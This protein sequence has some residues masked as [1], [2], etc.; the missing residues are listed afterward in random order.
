MLF[1]RSP[2]YTHSLPFLELSLSLRFS[3]VDID[4]TCVL[5]HDVRQYD[6]TDS[7]LLIDDLTDVVYD[8]D[9]EDV[10]VAVVVSMLHMMLRM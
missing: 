6:V 8:S 4:D 1:W 9:V 3:D 2:L 7:G 10:D 5:D